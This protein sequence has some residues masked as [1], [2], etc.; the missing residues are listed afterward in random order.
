MGG[1]F[2]SLYDLF[3]SPLSLPLFPPP[4]LLEKVWSA[5]T[6]GE[7]ETEEDEGKRFVPKSRRG[8]DSLQSVWGDRVGLICA[9]A[10]ACAI[11]F[12]SFPFG[13]MRRKKK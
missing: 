13:L 11:T 7:E 12:L 9:S 4:R 8:K 1:R 10:A 2:L 5:R 3:P 6:A